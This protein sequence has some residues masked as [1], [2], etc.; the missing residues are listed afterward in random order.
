MSQKPESTPKPFITGV[1]ETIGSGAV[2]GWAFDSRDPQRRVPVDLKLDGKYLATVTACLY[3][4]DLRVLG[5][6]DAFHAFSYPLPPEVLDGFNHVLE[7]RIAGT[8]QQLKFSPLD[9]IEWNLS[10][11]MQFPEPVDRFGSNPKRAPARQIPKIP[12][13]KRSF[14]SS[15]PQG[16]A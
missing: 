12:Q 1:L 5:S 13:K 10:R 6:G 8:D 7:A 11:R 9:G 2:G 14:S 4:H 16:A 3:R 15:S